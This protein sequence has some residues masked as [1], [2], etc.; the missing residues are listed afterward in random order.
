MKIFLTLVIGL[1]ILNPA[2]TQDYTFDLE[3]ISKVM[4]DADNSIK[5]LAHDH[6]YFL[7][8]EI[9][10]ENHK[11]PTSAEGLKNA[12]G[13]GRDNTGFGVDIRIDSD[14]LYVTSLHEEL[15][16]ELVIYL[17]RSINITISSLMRSTISIEGFDGEIV[18][19]NHKGD[20][21]MKNV[22]GPIVA[23]NENG[24]VIIQ[25]KELSQV[26]PSSIVMEN[27]DVDI[28]FPKSTR[29]TIESKLRFGK[30]Y[31]NFDLG[32]KSKNR[33]RTTALN[34]GGAQLFLQS[35]AGDVRLREAE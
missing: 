4:I 2:F 25:F 9:E 7:I 35:I 3:G 30:L 11:S 22:T 10:N 16:N 31:S 32:D 6:N 26:S 21:S 29:V 24:D 13:K 33:S 20:I 8:R 19:R 27:G 23:Q 28:T 5:L 12:N 15:A 17:P 1:A 14:R 34:G 18:A